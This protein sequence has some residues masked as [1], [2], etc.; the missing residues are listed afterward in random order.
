MS[1][2]FVIAY[3]VKLGN[4]YTEIK[5]FI[6]KEGVEQ[7]SESV[8]TFLCDRNSDYLLMYFAKMF[9]KNDI[10]HLIYSDFDRNLKDENLLFERIKGTK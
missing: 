4:E 10:A 1:K 7:L 2:R 3:D 8:Y 6:N 5:E 9:K